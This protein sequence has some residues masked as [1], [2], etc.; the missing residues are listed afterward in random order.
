MLGAIIGDIAGSRFEFNNTHRKDFE[1]FAEDCHITDDSIM[2]L[3]IAK[4]ILACNGDWEQL[5]NNTVK[6]MQEIGRKYPDCGFG[7]MFIKWVFDDNPKPYNSYGNGAAMRV[8]PCGFIARTME[9]AVL[10]SRKVT[11]VTHNHKE[12]IKGAEAVSVAI[13][14][15]RNG[16]VKNE[17]KERIEKDYYALN[18]TL[19]SIRGDY[20]FDETCQGTVPQAITA[21]LES[22]SFEDAIRNAV[23]IGG[24]SDTLAA[25][26]GS[27]AQAYY[28]VPID[29]KCKAQSYIDRS[30]L[31]I[32]REWEKYIKKTQP[33]RKFISL[34]KYIGKLEMPNYY[35]QFCID[36]YNFLPSHLEYELADYENI[37]EEN[38]LIW[39]TESMQSADENN[40]GEQ[41]ILA[42]I[43]GAFRADHFSGGVLNE[44]IKDGYIDK[45]LGRLKALDDERKPQEDRPVL[46][47]VKIRL[48]PFQKETIAELLITENEIVIKSN[49]PDGGNVTH[50]YEYGDSSEFSEL[51]LNAMTD[52]LEA[53]GWNDVTNYDKS[54]LTAYFYELDAEYEDGNTVSHHGL[55]NRTHIPEKTFKAFIDTIH[56]ATNV[57][58]FGEILNLDGFMSAI[59]SG[60]VKY[61]GVEFSDGGSIY[62]Y[63]TT[64]LRI[65][66]GDIVIVPVGKDNEEKKAIIKTVDYCRW[67]DTPYPLEKTKQ[68]IRKID[69]RSSKTPLLRFS[70]NKPL[71]CSSEEDFIDYEEE[72]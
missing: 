20:H 24:D 23:S 59:K 51:C 62:H 17:I 58:G 9:E 19:D 26:T 55:F 49:K 46:K 71:L 52:C 66:V 4:A 2:T 63:R 5:E 64:D 56:V 69:D 8:S 48:F 11:E 34:T 35:N 53:E 14:M 47:N 67:D 38:G 43:T 28:G 13:F 41:C 72:T 33:V 36:F 37:L 31:K 54:E 18:F 60:E 70:T 12:G 7:G 6:Y 16:A 1:L 50:K 30:L 68:I 39:Q 21:F 44:F 57:Y 10:L 65:N 27:I 3:A 45:W 40:F 61:C 15:A 22:V 25:I 29:L 42:L 32:Y